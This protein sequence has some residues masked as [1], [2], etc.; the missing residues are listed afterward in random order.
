MV[1]KTNV[2]TLWGY[3]VSNKFYANLS[4]MHNFLQT[5]NDEIV[6]TSWL[7]KPVTFFYNMVMSLF[8]LD[9]H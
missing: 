1:R 8:S 7:W 3:M 9:N 2:K 5:N 4:Y 6:Q